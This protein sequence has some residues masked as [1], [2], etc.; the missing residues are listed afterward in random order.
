MHA[1]RHAIFFAF[2]FI[3]DLLCNAVGKYSIP[4]VP[5]TTNEDV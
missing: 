5:L 4:E 2:P 3:S 1:Y